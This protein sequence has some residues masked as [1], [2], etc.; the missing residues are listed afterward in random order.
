MANVANA[1]VYIARV[2]TTLAS[3]LAITTMHYRISNLAGVFTEVE[4]ANGIRSPI[5]AAYA[6]LMSDQASLRG[7]GV[8]RVFPLPPRATAFDGLAATAGGDASDALP[9]QICG[10]IAKR[11]QFAGRKF[12]GRMYIPFP[13]EA[14]NDPT[15]GRPS[16]AYQ[17]GLA[18]LAGLWDNVLSLVGGG[19]GCDATPVIWHAST[20]THDD[21]TS[22]VARTFWGTQRR[23]GD[24][25]AT[26]ISPI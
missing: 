26:N 4:L 22:C 3:Q 25:G 11:T 10:V 2:Y 6:S 19:G 7:V 16:A 1:E 14:A 13:A 17:A 20:S 21:I 8:Q 23:R 24:F 5:N 12:R 9:K 18:T 15:Q